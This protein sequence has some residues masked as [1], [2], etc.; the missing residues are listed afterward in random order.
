[1]RKYI[2]RTLSSSG[3]LVFTEKHGV[4]HFICKDKDDYC[5]AA[6]KVLK[7]RFEE[8]WYGDEKE[9]LNPDFPG[10]QEAFII[11]E[12]GDNEAAY[13]FMHQRSSEIYAEYEEMEIFYSE[14]Y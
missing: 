11:T 14:E 9:P 7:E 12:D 2:E 5:R 13:E 6:M 1:M 3:I 10:G 4:R 8:G